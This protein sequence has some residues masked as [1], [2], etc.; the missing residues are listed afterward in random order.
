MWSVGI[1]SY[2]T[3]SGECRF[4]RN[5]SRID[6]RGKE[7]CIEYPALGRYQTRLQRLDSRPS[8]SWWGDCII[9]EK[10]SLIWRHDGVIFFFL[11]TLMSQNHSIS[12]SLS[13]YLSCVFNSVTRSTLSIPPRFQ[14]INSRSLDPLLPYWV[15][16]YFFVRNSDMIFLLVTERTIYDVLYVT[17]WA[18]SLNSV[19]NWYLFTEKRICP[20][21]WIP[22]VRNSSA[23]GLPFGVLN[24]F[25]VSLPDLELYLSWER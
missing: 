16:K 22:R 7:S 2:K 18:K 13:C 8:E 9:A 19:W 21:L 20:W 11:M 23:E 10:S 15:G 12:V 5:N 14:W 6:R 1:M 17:K 4:S 24:I 3:L 25:L